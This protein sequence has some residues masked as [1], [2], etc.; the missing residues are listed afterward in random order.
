LGKKKDFQGNGDREGGRCGMSTKKGQ[1]MGKG[2]TARNWD[3]GRERRT[4]IK[5]GGGRGGHKHHPKHGQST[6]ISGKNGTRLR[7]QELE[8]NLQKG[9]KIRR[10]RETSKKTFL[11]GKKKNCEHEKSGRERRG[12]CQS[13]TQPWGGE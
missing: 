2:P 11:G 6:K 7:I 1:K 10:G 13:I 9:S 8:K 5:G 12:I 4:D 3:E